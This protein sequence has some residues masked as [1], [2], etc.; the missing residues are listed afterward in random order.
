M[1]TENGFFEFAVSKVPRGIYALAS[2]NAQ[3]ALFDHTNR[4]LALS[5]AIAGARSRW[6]SG[7]QSP[8]ELEA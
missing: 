7:T 3:R 6:K 4:S 5:K 8:G 2:D 1:K